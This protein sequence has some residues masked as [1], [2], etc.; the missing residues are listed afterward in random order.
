MTLLRPIR[1]VHE[2]LP[3]FRRTR[4]PTE[5]ARLEHDELIRAR[6]VLIGETERIRRGEEAPSPELLR[7][8]A[9]ATAIITQRQ[10]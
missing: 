5:T 6:A 9:K 3:S 4:T 7:R 1:S 8:L 10:I 2:R